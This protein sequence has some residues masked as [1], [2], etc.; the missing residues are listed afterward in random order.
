MKDLRFEWDANKDKANIKK[1]GVS[2][3][4]RA[5]SFMMRMPFDSSIRTI[6]RMKTASFYS[7]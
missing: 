6:R 4:E 1:H 7:E 5:R 3:D 2:F